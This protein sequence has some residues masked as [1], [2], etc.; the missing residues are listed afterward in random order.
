MYASS[1]KVTIQR[2]LGEGEGL[3]NNG[4][5]EDC[6]YFPESQNVALEV[7]LLF[8]NTPEPPW[9]LGLD[10]SSSQIHVPSAAA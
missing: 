10:G 7:F 2:C 8:Y 9:G 4:L 5:L 3:A 1:L 6:T